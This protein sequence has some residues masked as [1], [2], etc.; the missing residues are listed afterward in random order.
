MYINLDNVHRTQSLSVSVIFSVLHIL[1]FGYGWVWVVLGHPTD[2]QNTAGAVNHFR[3]DCTSML[4]LYKK[5]IAA[6]Y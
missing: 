1:Y 2:N 6:F 4:H 5:V 3:V